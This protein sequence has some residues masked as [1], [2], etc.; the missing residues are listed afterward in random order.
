MR[1]VGDVL[2]TSGYY[3]LEGFSSEILDRFGVEIRRY[4]A[5][6]RVDFRRACEGTALAIVESPSNPL[7]T[8]TDTASTKSE[9]MGWAA[10]ML[11]P[12]VHFVGGH[13][14]AG[15]E[16]PGID[17]AEATLFKGATY[18][19]FPTATA[20]PPDAEVIE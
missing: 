15:K 9:V 6:D 10:E 13:P 17:G 19:V 7:L 5:R 20:H 1:A 16:T 3:S 14:M 4:D 18:C 8:L 2:K 12:N 11:P